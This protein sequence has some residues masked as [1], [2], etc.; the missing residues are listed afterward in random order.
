MSAEQHPDTR[1]SARRSVARGSSV[2]SRR[3]RC[4][5]HGLVQARRAQARSELVA[6]LIADHIPGR[7]AYWDR[8]LR[9]RF[10]NRGYHE[11]FDLSPDQVLGRRMGELFAPED[12]AQIEPNV[13]AALRGEMQ[14][15]EAEVRGRSP[16]W[17][18]IQYLPDVQDGRVRGFVVLALDISV[19]K[20]AELALK[21][22]NGE[23]LVARDKAE[24]ASRAKSAFL[25]HMS[26]EI[27]TPMNAILGL[28]HLL[29]RDAQDE[30]A[31]RRLRD[32]DGSA[33][34]LLQIINDVLDMSRIESGRLDLEGVDFDSAALVS[35]SVAQV[36]DAAA[37]KGLELQVDLG[38]LPLRLHGDPTR[39]MQ[40]L[41]NLLSNAVKFTEQGAV[42]VAARVLERTGQNLLLRFEVRDSGIGIS[43]EAMGRL[44]TPF[45]QADAGNARRYGGTGLGLAITRHL[46][47]KMGGDAGAQSAVGAGSLF[48]FTVQLQLGEM[49]AAK[50]LLAQEAPLLAPSEAEQLLRERHAGRRV[51]LAEDDP[52]NQMVV[53]SL[54]QAAGLE[55]DMVGDG[56]Q[57][58]R[59]ARVQRYDAILMDMEM[60]EMNG[61]D[62]CR[63]IR[64]DTV[65]ALTPIVALTGNAF[66][67]DREACLAAGM[68]DFLPKPVAPELLY[69]SLLNL[70]G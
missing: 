64:R 47:R 25:A 63:A 51:L 29:R 45:E 60:P 20:R 41:L 65:H 59:R 43:A 55:V 12:W 68:D 44:F 9:C 13:N 35:R 6:R 37:S 30:L 2:V 62:A 67:S 36:A 61:L 28:T 31:A 42:W 27:R 52:V 19:R 1:A 32:I 34:H 21:D 11:W 54:L 48:W 46:A 57:A 69:A 56:A 14:S 10:A 49:P 18:W 15:F 7:I 33:Q 26:H 22:I 24:A 70:L 66:S 53:W 8:Q 17:Q 5:Q 50:A 3:Q 16:D 40:M 39:L 23:L 58:L 38:D 4:Y